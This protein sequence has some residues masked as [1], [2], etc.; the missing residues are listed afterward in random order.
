M[1]KFY[2]AFSHLESSGGVELLRTSTKSGRGLDVIPIPKGGFTVNYLRSVLGQARY[3]LRPIQSD[4][5]DSCATEYDGI[6]EL[7]GELFIIV[8]IFD[9]FTD[10][11]TCHVLVSV[12]IFR[13]FNFVF[14]CILHLILTL[15]PNPYSNPN[16][17]TKFT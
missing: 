10:H 9:F 5:Q 1:N 15:S 14:F 12:T 8:F 4:L 11:Y 13:L 7:V 16:L 6:D 2:E 17:D 3:Y